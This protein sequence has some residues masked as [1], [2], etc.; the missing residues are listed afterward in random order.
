MNPR[1]HLP[2]VLALTAAGAALIGVIDLYAE[3]VQWAVGLLLIL[4]GVGAALAPRRWWAVALIAGAGVPV[5][6]VV[7]GL[8][9]VPS[10][11]PVTPPYA[12]VLAFIPAIIGALIGASIGGRFSAPP[13]APTSTSP[14]AGAPSPRP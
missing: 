9:G 4:A 6:H 14:S 1:A 8:L 3:Q 11:Y 5:T 2:L 10:H 7:A 12:T 13:S